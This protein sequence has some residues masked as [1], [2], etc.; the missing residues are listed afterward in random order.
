MISNG[1][2][3]C[4]STGS[5]KL[6][7]STGLG[8]KQSLCVTHHPQKHPTGWGCH[9]ILETFW[10]WEKGYS[11]LFLFLSQEISPQLPCR[12]LFTLQI[13]KDLALGRL[14][15]SDNC[16]A[17][18]V[19]HILQCKQQMLSLG[20]INQAENQAKELS[21]LNISTIMLEEK[22]QIKYIKI[23]RGC[24]CSYGNLDSNTVS[25]TV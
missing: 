7:S 23:E 2:Q 10:I 8:L 11:F 4:Q 15:C 16:T 22:V 6:W 13:K 21:T 17:L 19:S 18:M 5:T 24:H 1:C 9:L 3:S 12:Y 25:T 20:H 14:P